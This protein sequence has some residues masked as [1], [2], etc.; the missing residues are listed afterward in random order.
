MALNSHARQ[1][2]GVGCKH[3]LNPT[4]RRL[5]D[6]RLQVHAGGPSIGVVV[7]DLKDDEEGRAQTLESLHASHNGYSNIQPLLLSASGST[8]VDGVLQVAVT[9]DTW[10]A[11]LNQV[12]QDAEFEWL[13][14]AQAGEVFTANGLLLASLELLVAPDCRAVYCDQIYRQVDGGLGVGFRPAFNLDYLLSFPV[15]MAHHWLFRR[16]LL[17]QIGGFDAALPCAV[18]LDVILRLIIDGGLAGLGHVSEPLLTT[19]TPVL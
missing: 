18:E 11:V 16:D 9:C 1:A 13:I 8:V 7:L 15:G 19:E 17:L 6:E 2:Y 4:Q 3:E 5:L 14:L 10:V 12:L